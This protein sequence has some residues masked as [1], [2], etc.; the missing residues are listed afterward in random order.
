[1]VILYELHGN[2]SSLFH[3]RTRPNHTD[4]PIKMDHEISG[5]NQESSAAAKPDDLC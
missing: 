5:K 2:R 1:M 3:A 4:S